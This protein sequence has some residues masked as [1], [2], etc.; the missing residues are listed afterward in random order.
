MAQVEEAI[1][2]DQ[3]LDAETLDTREL[4]KEAARMTRRKLLRAAAECFADHGYHK[5]TIRQIASRAGVTLGALYH[6]FKDKRAL[7]IWVNRARQI[8]SSQILR[9]AMSEEEDFFAALR[10]GLRGQFKVLA[11]NPTL[12]GI[13]REYMGMSMTDPDFNRM[14]NRSDLEFYGFF[15]NEL[16]RR[17]PSLRPET[18]DAFV[19]MLIVALEG[20]IIQ[21][22][23]NSPMAAQPD[24]IVNT[25]VDTFETA[26]KRRS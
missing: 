1:S 19:R 2:L 25:F 15:I 8:M 13:T 14:H 22:V 24:Q 3:V 21:V 26:V 12:C 23:A 9:N 20:L 7:L 17:Y 5:T 6:H 18:R 4:H 16:E 10:K 11:D